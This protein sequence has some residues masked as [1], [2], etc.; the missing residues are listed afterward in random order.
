MNKKMGVTVSKISLLIV[1]FFCLSGFSTSSTIQKIS[2]PDVDSQL[3]LPFVDDF[4]EGIREEWVLKGN[5][6]PLLI[7]G[8]L[9]AKNRKEV[10]LEIGDNS[11]DKYILEFDVFY[12]Y[13]EASSISFVVNTTLKMWISPWLFNPTRLYWY[14]FADNDWQLVDKQNTNLLKNKSERWKITREK[15]YYE[16]FRNGEIINTFQYGSKDGSPLLIQIQSNEIF[17]D[18]FSIKELVDD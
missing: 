5:D 14:E 2:I 4:N 3:I 18:N 16:V 6:K 12:D 11:L 7:N 15:D 10:S 17:I 8:M 1:L 13:H 9:T